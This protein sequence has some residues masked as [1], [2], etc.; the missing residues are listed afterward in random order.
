[1]WFYLFSMIRDN[2]YENVVGTLDNITKCIIN[3]IK[4]D[5]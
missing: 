2:S 4:R 3:I 1:M 5:N